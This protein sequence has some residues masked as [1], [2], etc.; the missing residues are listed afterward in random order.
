MIVAAAG[1]DRVARHFVCRFAVEREPTGIDRVQG[2]I[3]TAPGRATRDIAD[4]R[5]A[6]DALVVSLRATVRNG[7]LVVDE[8]TGLPDGTVLALVIDDEGD[9]LDDAQRRALD[10]AIEL[11]LQQADAGL[12]AP[13]DE[14]LTRLRARRSE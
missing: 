11:S 12:V 6:G 10:A 1:A 3:G 13:G 7:R 14:I 9:D 4:H 8:A 2:E 5:P